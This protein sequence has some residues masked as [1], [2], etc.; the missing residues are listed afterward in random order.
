MKHFE[1]LIIWKESRL[2]VNEIYKISRKTN[3]FGF[4]DQI[5][6]A[7]ISVMNNIA[8]G[9][10]SGTDA[11]F[12]KYLNIAKASCAEVRSMLYLSEDFNIIDTDKA[13]LLRNNTITISSRI[14]QLIQYLKKSI[15]K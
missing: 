14:F 5:Q 2:L 1:E 12:I 3:D 7:A 11:S 10:E 6:R 4:K 8:E 13:A 15:T 9:A